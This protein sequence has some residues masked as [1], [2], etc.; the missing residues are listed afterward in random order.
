[1]VKLKCKSQPVGSTSKERGSFITNVLI[2]SII[3]CVLAFGFV[4]GAADRTTGSTP[5]NQSEGVV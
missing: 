3:A 2:P 4:N 1:M 5:S